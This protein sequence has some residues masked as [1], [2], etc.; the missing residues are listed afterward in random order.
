MTVTLTGIRI[1][2][3]ESA[4]MHD[5]QQFDT[6]ADFDATLRAASGCAPAD[7]RYFKIA[8]TATW[9]DG[10][11]YDGRID[12]ERHDYVGLLPH[13]VAACQ[14]VEREPLCADLVPAARAFRARFMLTVQQER[15]AES[16]RREAG[17][18]RKLAELRSEMD[19]CRQH[20]D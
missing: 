7:G 17:L 6:I 8:F 20:L 15:V 13:V 19:S 16:L 2:Y 14:D 12:L 10:A 9:S 3:S 18:A 11:V 4:A 1:R 5:G